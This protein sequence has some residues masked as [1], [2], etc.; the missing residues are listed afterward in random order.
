MSLP[1]NEYTVRIQEEFAMSAYQDLSTPELQA[2]LKELQAQYDE[3][4][5]KG[6]KLDV[7]GK[8]RAESAGPFDAA[9]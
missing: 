5:T 6:L 9:A 3:F 8:T 4:K 2:M 7:Q 1:Q